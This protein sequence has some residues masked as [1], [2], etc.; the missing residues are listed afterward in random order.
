MRRVF[1]IAL[2]L[3]ALLAL[4]ASGRASD[5][6]A[7]YRFLRSSTLTETG[8]FAG[9]NVD[10]R[11]LGKYDFINPFALPQADAASARFAHVDA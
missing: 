11:V 4:T 9:V 7:H 6:F 10:Y 3:A 1:V 2:A 8:G 5:A